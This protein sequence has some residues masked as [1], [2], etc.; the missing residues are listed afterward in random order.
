M[1]RQFSHKHGM[2]NLFQESAAGAD[3]HTLLAASQHHIYPMLAFEKA[4]FLGS[5]Y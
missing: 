4:N 2:G 5:Y 1:Q 3:D